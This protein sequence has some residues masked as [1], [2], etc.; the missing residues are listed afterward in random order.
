M[1][2]VKKSILVDKKIPR[3]LCSRRGSNSRYHEEDEDTY[4][5]VLDDLKVAE[6]EHIN[7]IEIA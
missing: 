4:R 6:T 1:H 7:S 2:E 3:A 5:P